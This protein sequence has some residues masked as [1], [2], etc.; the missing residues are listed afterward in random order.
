MSEEK[1]SFEKP[2][3][4]WLERHPV[5]HTLVML[6]IV[7]LISSLALNLYI[8]NFYVDNLLLLHHATLWVCVTLIVVPMV[9]ALLIGGKK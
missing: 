1:T 6:G 2:K 9:Y 5:I 8:Y 3:K 4:V 7:L